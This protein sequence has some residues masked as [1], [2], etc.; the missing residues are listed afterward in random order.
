MIV[1]GGL[2]LFYNIVIGSITLLGIGGLLELA[3]PGP[4]HEPEPYDGYITEDDIRTGL[5]SSDED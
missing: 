1:L 4:G 3:E 2:D 5:Y